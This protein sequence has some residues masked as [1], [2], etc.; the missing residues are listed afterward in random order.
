MRITIS[1]ATALKASAPAKTNPI[2][3]LKTMTPSPFL[4]TK[5]NPAAGAL[6]GS[7][8]PEGVIENQQNHRSD[9]RHEETVKVESG[10]ARGS[11]DMEQPA[12]GKSA[13]NAQQDVEQNALASTVHDLA[14][15]EPGNQTEND[16]SQERHR[17]PRL[18]CRQ[19]QRRKGSAISANCP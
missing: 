1:A 5:T 10:Y 7:S 17:F 11:K 3:R 9:N 19:T 8:P 16:P 18:S 14:A 13:D 15:D 4:S 12:T 2:T 6:P